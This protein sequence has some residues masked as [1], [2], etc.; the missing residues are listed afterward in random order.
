MEN[1]NWFLLFLGS[2][3]VIPQVTSW[4][5]QINTE[6]WHKWCK[7]ANKISLSLI[8]TYLWHKRWLISTSIFF[9]KM[10]QSFKFHWELV[11]IEISSFIL[12]PKFISLKPGSNFLKLWNLRNLLRIFIQILFQLPW[13]IFRQK[14]VKYLENKYRI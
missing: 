2:I 10:K 5:Y 4:E 11:Y 3:L 12:E 9:K 7:K 14:N 13:N 8:L 1:S 6:I